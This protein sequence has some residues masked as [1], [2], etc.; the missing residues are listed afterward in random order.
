MPVFFPPGWC[1][2]FFSAPPQWPAVWEA[3]KYFIAFWVCLKKPFKKEF[4]K[5]Q[6]KKNKGL[7]KIDYYLESFKS[8]KKK[9]E[10]I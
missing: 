9:Y 4:L 1:V 10:Y 5:P 8:P 7:K 6:W 2:C 3:E